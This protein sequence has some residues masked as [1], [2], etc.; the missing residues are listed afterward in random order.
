MR[1]PS[2]RCRAARALSRRSANSAS[3]CRSRPRAP[4]FRRTRVARARRNSGRRVA[5]LRRARAQAAHGAARGRRRLR[6]EPHRARHS[7][8]SRRRQ[9]GLARR[10][11]GRDRRRSDRDQAL[12]ADA[13]GLS[14]RRVTGRQSSTRCRSRELI[15]AFCDQVWLQDGLARVDRSRA[16]AAISPRGRRWLDAARQYAARRRSAADVE[17]FL[18][19]QFRAKAKATSIARRLSSLRRFYRAAA[20]A[21]ARMRADPTLRVRAPKLPRRLPKNLSEDRGRGAA[22]ARRIPRRT[23]GLRDRAMLETLYATG[24]RVSELV[25]LTLAQVCA[26]HGRRA[27]ARQGQQGAA[28]PAGRRSRSTGSSAIS[29][30]AR[31]EL[32][33]N[34]KSDSGVRHR[35]PRRR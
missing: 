29:P 9:P 32:V 27:R 4:P 30:T 24:L 8:P 21:G 1:S 6:R 33:G 23:L 25:G 14:L 31:A 26:R 11:H 13:R 18:A 28:R 16:I 12:A 5:H 34:G 20:A 3:R 35:A 7:V 17:A 19:E 2:A 15:D 10:L 22:R